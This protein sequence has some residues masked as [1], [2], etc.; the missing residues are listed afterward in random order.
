[1]HG[2]RTRGTHGIPKAA[3]PLPVM[4]SLRK[5]K[6]LLPQHCLIYCRILAKTNGKKLTCLTCCRDSDEDKILIY[7]AGLE[8]NSFRCNHRVWLEGRY[9]NCLINEVFPPKTSI[10]L[11]FYSLVYF[12]TRFHSKHY[13]WPDSHKVQHTWL[14]SP[15]FP[16][17]TQLP[18]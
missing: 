1:M 4:S 8:S 17:L 13:F 12:H 16:F 7:I 6:S 9:S 5:M 18:H 2:G 15:S 11:I 3:L 14:S 10:C